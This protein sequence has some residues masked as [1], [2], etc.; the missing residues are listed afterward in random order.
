M[1]LALCPSCHR[2]VKPRDPRCPFCGTAMHASGGGAAAAVATAAVLVGLGIAAVGCSS[3]TE[4]NDVALY[5]GPPDTG[6]EANADAAYGPPPDT[7]VVDSAADA[8]D[9]NPVVLYGPPPPD[10]GTD[11]LPSGAYGPPPDTGAG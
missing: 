3:S 11:T 5:G 10:T 7:G 9:S 2:H 4:P 6:A 8:D 1:A